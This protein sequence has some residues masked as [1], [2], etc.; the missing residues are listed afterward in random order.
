MVQINDDYFEDLTPENFN[1]LLDDLAAGREVKVGSQSGRTTSEPATGLTTLTSLYGQD[2]RGGTL[3]LAPAP[4]ETTRDAE[5][6]EVYANPDQDNRPHETAHGGI[7]MSRDNTTGKP[8]GSIEN[9]DKRTDDPVG[10]NQVES[11]ALTQEGQEGDRQER[12]PSEKTAVPGP[13]ST[14]EK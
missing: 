4:A 7:D 10:A 2:G 6:P 8:Q 14:I 11:R 3:H 5:M 13:G 9:T 1:T 12:S